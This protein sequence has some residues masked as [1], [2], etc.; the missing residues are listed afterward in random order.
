M[1]TRSED[2]PWFVPASSF[3]SWAVRL[4]DRLGQPAR[5][6]E[7][8]TWASRII[9]RARIEEWPDQLTREVDK[10][11][12]RGGGGGG[13][14]GGG[15]EEREEREAGKDLTFDVVRRADGVAVG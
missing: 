12:G 4:V 14:E 15:E 10:P 11:R 1:S 6:L 7:Q 5:I 13:G 2:R 3:P 9:G 8:P